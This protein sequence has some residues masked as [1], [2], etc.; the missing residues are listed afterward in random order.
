MTTKAIN[1]TEA[2]TI[3]PRVTGVVDVDIAA[4]P[5]APIEKGTAAKIKM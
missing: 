4:V 1:I 3:R 2:K 5:L